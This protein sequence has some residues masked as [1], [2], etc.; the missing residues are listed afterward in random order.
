MVPGFGTQWRKDN[1]TDDISGLKLTTISS[2]VNAWGGMNIAGIDSATGQPAVYWWTP[3]TNQWVSQLIPL[4]G[5]P[6]PWPGTRTSLKPVLMG[7]QQNL[8]GLSD[9]TGD[10]VRLYW[11][12][13][14]GSAWT[15]ENLTRL[16]M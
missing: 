3:S 4:T 5:A 15:I 10:V 13:G 8:I 6:S 1:L 2:F 14:D 7:G 9:D 12:P 16:S 11:N